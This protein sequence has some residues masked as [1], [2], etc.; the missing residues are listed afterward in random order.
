MTSDSL[1]V[2]VTLG[3]DTATSTGE[4][5]QPGNALLEVEA[6]GGSARTYDGAWRCTN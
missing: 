2:T 4:Q 1:I 6:A 3:D 5:P